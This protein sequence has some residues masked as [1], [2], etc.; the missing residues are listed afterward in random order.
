MNGRY[1]GLTGGIGAGKSTVAAAL[2][3]C[4]AVV[5]DADRISREALDPGTDAYEKTVARFGRG[6]LFADGTVDRKALAGIVFADAGA[7][8][9]LNAIIHPYVR[10]AMLTMA[11]KAPENAMVVFDVPLLFESGMDRD[12]DRIVAVCA[13]HDVRVERVMLR[14]GATREQAESR[15]AAQ[16][17]QELLIKKADDVLMN[18][19]TA[20]DLETAARALYER[21]RQELAIDNE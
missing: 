16:M 5:L 8:G 18:N 12:V 6:I 20:A 2:R 1:I 14:D 17:D 3:D 4:G 9:D 7:R 10:N 15:M 21:Y 13:D 19:G 11:G